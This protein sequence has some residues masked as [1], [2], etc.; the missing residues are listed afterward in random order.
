MREFG[1]LI[2]AFVVALGLVT[3]AD[4]SIMAFRFGSMSWISP[5][6]SILSNVF[7]VT[8]IRARQR[9]HST[10]FVAVEYVL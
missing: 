2:Q 1:A 9:E 7:A 10:S 3:A 6:L 5:I 8:K 4:P